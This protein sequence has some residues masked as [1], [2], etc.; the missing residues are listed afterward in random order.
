MSPQPSG[1]SLAPAPRITS[2]SLNA[3]AAAVCGMSVRG[4]AAAAALPR[5]GTGGTDLRAGVGAD[6]ARADPQQEEEEEGGEEEHEGE[7]VSDGG[8]DPAVMDDARPV[9]ADARGGA[10]FVEVVKLWRADPYAAHTTQ[11]GRVAPPRPAAAGPGDPG[12]TEHSR[13][14]TAAA[15]DAVVS[16][17][18]AQGDE[19]RR[20]AAWEEKQR[21]AE[22]ERGHRPHLSMLILKT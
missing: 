21:A 20:R 6:G 12:R 7:E 8:T 14:A 5:C 18:L 10:G 3:E 2:M 1:V 17:L 4:A 19:R 15:C 13:A 11:S 16:R 22:E 9:A